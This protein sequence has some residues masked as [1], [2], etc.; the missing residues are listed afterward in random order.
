MVIEIS[1]AKRPPDRFALL[2]NKNRTLRVLLLSSLWCCTS[3]AVA[4]DTSASATDSGTAEHFPHYPV[5]NG[6][7]SGYQGYS[8]PARWSLGREAGDAVL[9]IDPVPRQPHQ[10]ASL[11]VIRCQTASQGYLFQDVDLLS[12]SWRLR[13]EVCGGQGGKS[14]LEVSGSISRQSEPIDVASAWQP[15]ELVIPRVAGPTRIHLRFQTGAAAVIKFRRVRLD[16][17]RLNSTPVP[18]EGGTVLGGLL[19]PQTPSPAE[20]F[21]AFELQRYVFRMTG[22]IPGLEGRDR[23]ATGHLIAIG[24]AAPSEVRRRLDDLPPDAYLLHR[25]ATVTSLVGNRGLS[26]LYAVYTFLSQ[27]GCYWVMPGELGEVIPRRMALAPTVSRVVSPDFHLVRSFFTGFQQFFPQGGWIYINTDDY[28]D[29]ALRNRFNAVWSGGATLDWG[30]D[31]GHG[32]IQNSG[33]SWNALVAP[34]QKYFDQHPEWYPLVRGRRMPRSDVS[35]RLPNQLCVSNQQLRDHTVQQILAYFRAN[36]RS[37][38]FPMN[39]M[40]GPNYNC[41]CANCRALDPPGHA[42][43]QDFSDHPRFPNLVLPPLADRYLNYVNH[44]AER[45]ARVHP[46]KLLEFYNYASRVPPTREQVHP[47]V[48]VKFTYLSGREMNVSLMD[49]RDPLARKERQWLDAWAHCGTRNL[50][51]Y[52]YT[53][54]EHPDAAIHWYY[55]TNDLLRHLKQRY[56][57]VGAMGETHTTVQAD[58]MWWGIYARTL[59]DIRTDYRALIGELCRA[60]YG[61]AASH[62]EAFY[63]SMD[64]ALLDREGPRPDGYHPNRRFEFSPAEIERGRDHLQRAAGQVAS[65]P[66]LLQRVDLARFAH[67]VLTVV[68]T[69]NATPRTDRAATLARQAFHDAKALRNKYTLLVRQPTYKLLAEA[70]E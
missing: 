40:D 6:D 37:Q 51:Y 1:G 53:D 29:W 14:L 62:M 3:W 16:A 13:A 47:N 23:T 57:C 58:P 26:T 39:P 30:A 25:G 18:L 31:R 2:G 46:D 8:R 49:P 67:A 28:R 69:R 9:A 61:P 19:L 38:M 50:T 15:L 56:G 63:L 24:T 33:H 32:W 65:S 66:R 36:P 7:F 5:Q 11:A 48:S 60:F 27:Q 59:W 54:W 43:N 12:G 45:V 17:I 55:N 20:R 70:D 10:G 21:A 64:N 42:W 41:E 35:I 4:S 44:V 68:R 22:R 52:P 34:Y